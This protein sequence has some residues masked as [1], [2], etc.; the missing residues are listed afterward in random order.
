MEDF[1]VPDQCIAWKTYPLI[2]KG[3]RLPDGYL[4]TPNEFV[5]RELI[6]HLKSLIVETIV[7][8]TRVPRQGN[9]RLTTRTGRH[10]AHYPARPAMASRKK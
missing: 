10:E 2:Q 6:V 9:L 8:A 4:S 5:K 1:E 7:K 3:K